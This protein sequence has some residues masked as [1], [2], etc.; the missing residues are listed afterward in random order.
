MFMLFKTHWAAARNAV[1]AY[2]FTLISA[3]QPLEHRRR[4]VVP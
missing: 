2:R 3:A 1:R 4:N